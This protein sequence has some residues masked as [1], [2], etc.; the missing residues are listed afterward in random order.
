MQ[1]LVVGEL[2]AVLATFDP[3]SMK[4]LFL[5][6]NSG[7]IIFMIKDRVDALEYLTMQIPT[8]IVF[9]L[10][11]PPVSYVSNIY[12]LPFTGVV[13]ICSISLVILYT[14]AIASTL[15][16]HWL[17]NEPNQN[18]KASDY[19]LFAVA[20]ACQMGTHIFTKLLSARISMVGIQ[21]AAT[22]S[23]PH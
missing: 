11:S 3:K 4:M 16:F 1:I 8:S 13:W 2:R 12:Y 10:R 18:M 23:C 5:S 17:P 6:F 19:F 14:V 22:L 21:T 7:T 9:I 15:H 20:S